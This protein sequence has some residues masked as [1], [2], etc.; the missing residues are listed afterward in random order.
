MQHL[1][2]IPDPEDGTL[3][4]DSVKIQFT[5]GLNEPKVDIQKV[6]GKG[7]CGDISGGFYYDDPKAPT[8]L[9]L[10]PASCEMIHGGTE[11][12]SVRVL[13]GCNKPPAQ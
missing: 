1:L 3:D 4:L 13:L 5:P 11:N 6:G 7:L 9:I 12:A 8:R 10:C 2:P